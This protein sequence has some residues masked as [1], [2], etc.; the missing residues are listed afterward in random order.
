MNYKRFSEIPGTVFK[1]SIAF[2]DRFKDTDAKNLWIKA[3]M[4]Y[5][6][7]YGTI[8]LTTQLNKE[9]QLLQN[10]ILKD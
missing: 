9:K 5:P 8:Y 2:C 3:V 1:F 6:E 4:H 7:H 10:F